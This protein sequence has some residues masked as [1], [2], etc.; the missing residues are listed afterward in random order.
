VKRLTL[1]LIFRLIFSLI[2]SLLAVGCNESPYQ[3]SDVLDK[4]PPKAE[5]A[6]A[7]SVTFT[8]P[9]A[10]EMTENMPAQITVGAA[11]PRGQAVVNVQGLPTGATFD[12]SSLVLAWIPPANS[13]VDPANAKA[14]FRVY[15]VNF[16]L[17]N[18]ADPTLNV[19]R[20]LSITVYHPQI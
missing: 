18:P 3:D 8:M 10:I 7:P 12:P 14:G 9:S 20:T 19:Q 2:Y 13:G 11:V 6:R 15:T 4:T 17:T 16:T 5:K 1:R